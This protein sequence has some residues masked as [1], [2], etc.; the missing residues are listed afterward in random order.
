MATTTYLI[1]YGADP[2]DR[3]AAYRFVSR[4]AAHAASLPAAGLVPGVPP[5]ATAGGCAYVVENPADV[6]FGGAL[7]LKVYN[8]LSGKPP[9]A[10][11]EDRAAGVKRLMCLL[12]TASTEFQQPEENNEMAREAKI[13]EFKPIGRDTNIGKI[14]AAHQAG[15]TNIDD[16]AAQLGMTPEKAVGYLRVARGANGIDHAVAKETR[17]L[18][19]TIPEGVDVFKIAGEPKTKEQRAPRQPKF[20]NFSQVQASSRLGKIIAATPATAA[21][22]GVLCD[23]SADD[24][25]TNLRRARVSHGIDHAV[26]EDGVV[27]VCA[28]EMPADTVLIKPPAAVKPARETSGAK[29]P[30]PDN[31]TITLLVDKNPK[32]PTAAAYAR[33]ELY[34]NGQTAGEFLAAGGTKADLSWDRVH[35]FI[36]IDV[37]QAQATE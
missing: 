36:Q 17:E 24:V 13:G 9:V 12:E 4:A 22:I 3:L 21:D 6:T 18:T 31:A 25:I 14:V 19:L 1:V 15:T 29:S 10:R 37:L 33:F 27:T 35:G 16:L 8:G 30:I 7:L 34:R 26:A 5:G 32:R 23:L 20:G 2:S 28:Y 11:F